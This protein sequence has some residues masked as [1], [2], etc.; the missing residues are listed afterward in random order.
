MCH[1]NQSIGIFSSFQP[2]PAP[3]TDFLPVDKTNATDKG[4]SIFG[5]DDRRLFQDTNYPWGTTGKFRKQGGWCSGT[6]V[7][8]RHVLTASHCPTW[9]SD[10]TIGWATFTPGY[11]DGSG[12]VGEI[13]IVRFVFWEKAPP[14][15]TDQESAFDYVIGILDQDLT[16]NVGYVGYRTYDDHWND[17]AYWEY[18][19]YPSELSSGERPAYQGSCKISSKNDF[20]LSGQTGSLLGHFNEFTPGQSGGAAWGWWANEVFPRVVGVGSTI[21]D[22]V[23]KTTQNQDTDNEYGG[24]PAL[25]ALISY[26][27]DNWK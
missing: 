23:V 1:A 7:G 11:F 26:A 18:I 10:G 21:G 4:G 27:R 20:S 5:T 17:G 8:P 15:L 19:G 13:N 9:N 22:T 3:P 16:N 2:R 24:G 12:Y 14:F 25:S 6:M